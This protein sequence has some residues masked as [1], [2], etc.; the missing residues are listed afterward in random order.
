MPDSKLPIRIQQNSPQHLVLRGLGVLVVAYFLVLP[1]LRD[2]DAGDYGQLTDILVLALAALSL[3][4]LVG[5][6]GQISI[7]HSAF[8]GVGA[9]TT[10]ILMDTYEW[11]PGWTFP[12]AALLCFVV[13][14]LVGIPA[15]RLTGV[16]L[17]LVT[18]ALAQ[19]FPALVRKF[20]DLTG[21]STGIG[22]L[23][24]DPPEWL[25][26]DAGRSGRA[27]WLYFVALVLLGLS[28]VVQRNLVKSRAGRAMVAVRDNPTAAAV[29]GVNVSVTK[30]VVFGVSAAMAGLAGCVFA[31]RLSLVTPDN[32]N[33]QIVGAILFLVIMVI[34]GTGSLL[35]PIVGAFVF[36][37][38]DD[39]T[40]GLG[41]EDYL[42]GFVQDFLAGRPNLATIVMAVLLIA[43][44]YFAPYGIVGAAKKSARRLLVVIPNP[45]TGGRLAAEAAAAAATAPLP[46]DVP[47]TPQTPDEAER[48]QSSEPEG[49][50]PT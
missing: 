46:S 29:M 28:Y 36:H 16:Y 24:Y 32:I 10:A 48:T 35:G 6:T 18:L 33:F 19:L 39:Y 50:N 26:F 34:G 14:V 25:W 12:V 49:E 30:T 22:G 7:G 40:R 13:G 4:L 9:Y 20:S 31:L 44:M 2:Q 37:F 41:G 1:L 45:P 27:E 3:N 23:R 17:S 5:F 11:T 47:Q 15:L 38:L 42:P 8:F 21:G 43:A